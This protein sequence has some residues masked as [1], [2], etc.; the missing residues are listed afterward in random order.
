[1]D[2]LAVSWDGD[3]SLILQQAGL[4]LF[5]GQWPDPGQNAV[6]SRPVRLVT[7]LLS[8]GQTKSEVQLRSCRGTFCLSMGSIAKQRGK[9]GGRWPGQEKHGL[10]QSMTR[11]VFL[12]CC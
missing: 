12:T 5:T 3:G 2:K 6:L 10:L 4:G 7:L 1:M 9:G 8:V 11:V